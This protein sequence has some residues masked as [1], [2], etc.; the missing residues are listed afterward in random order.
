MQDACYMNV[1]YPIAWEDALIKAWVR[2]RDDDYI[3]Y[4]LT[5]F[6]IISVKRIAFPIGFT[7]KLPILYISSTFWK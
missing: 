4:V 6:K 5:P 1:F 7:I 2:I 3:Q